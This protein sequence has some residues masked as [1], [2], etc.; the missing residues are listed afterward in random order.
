MLSDSQPE[1]SALPAWLVPLSQTSSPEAR[2]AS[3]GIFHGL[4]SSSEKVQAVVIDFHLLRWCTWMNVL[5]SEPTALREEVQG[6][7]SEE[8]IVVSLKKANDYGGHVYKW[9]CKER[10]TVLWP[11]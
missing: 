4:D 7:T 9:T 1:G 11:H 8:R 3:L 5:C 10:A 6:L 2:P